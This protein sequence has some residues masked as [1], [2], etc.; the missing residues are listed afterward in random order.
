MPQNLNRINELDLRKRLLIAESELNR[1]QLTAAKA[2]LHCGLHT[3]T[4]GVSTVGA[5]A[6]SA[7]MLA[8]SLAA[9]PCKQHNAGKKSLCMQTVL[10]GAVLISSVYLALNPRDA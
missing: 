6:S 9:I 5:I 3:V 4:H 10:Y 2:G 7:A 8:T 1:T